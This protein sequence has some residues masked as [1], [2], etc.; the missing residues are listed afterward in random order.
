MARRPTVEPALAECIDQ[1]DALL[2]LGHS[3]VSPRIRAAMDELV[4]AL[5]EEPRPV[6][7]DIARQLGRLDALLRGEFAYNFQYHITVDG[8]TVAAAN[9]PKTANIPDNRIRPKGKRTH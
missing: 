5:K 3:D 9:I 1:L 2:R 7:V 4:D 8:K 6:S